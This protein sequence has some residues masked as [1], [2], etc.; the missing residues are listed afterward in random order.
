M[1]SLDGRYF[2]IAVSDVHLGHHVFGDDSAVQFDEFLGVL[3]QARNLDI[4]HFIILGDFID[5]WRDDDDLLFTKYAVLIERLS[6]LK[7]ESGKIKNLHYVVGNHDFVIPY[8]KER[9]KDSIKKLLE[10]FTVT[11]PNCVTPTS[12]ELPGDGSRLNGRKFIIRHGHQDEAGNLAMM[13]DMS[14]VLLCG[15]NKESGDFLS[16]IYKYKYELATSTLALVTSLLFLSSHPLV[17]GLFLILT[18]A[19]FLRWTLNYQKQ[20]KTKEFLEVLQERPAIR[21]KRFEQLDERMKMRE[22]GRIDKIIQTVQRPEGPVE[23]H[24]SRDYRQ[25]QQV[26]QK[27]LDRMPDRYQN[28][29]E[30]ILRQKEIIMLKSRDPEDILIRGHSH[31]VVNG[32]NNEY[33]PGGWV[34]ESRFCILTID[35]QGEVRLEICRKAETPSL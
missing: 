5:L 35:T 24:Q 12:L 26:L 30:Q 17:G 11:I 10:P 3:E 18:S 4:E 32:E 20:K 6:K 2:A 15:Q 29:Q 13:Y 31:I 34:E 19:A 23:F 28:V 9:G 16:K 22:Q 21:R 8:Y 27:R 25:M 1:V 33:N 7:T 14:A